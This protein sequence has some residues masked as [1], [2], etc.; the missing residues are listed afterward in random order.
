MIIIS[1]IVVHVQCPDISNANIMMSVWTLMR[2]L[3]HSTTWNFCT[4][5]YFQLNIHQ[6]MWF[7]TSVALRQSLH[8]RTVLLWLCAYDSGRAPSGHSIG[9]M[10]QP[11][12]ISWLRDCSQ[13]A[14][15]H[16]SGAIFTN[17]P[18]IVQ[19]V[20]EEDL[21]MNTESAVLDLKP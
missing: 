14:S 10:E 4:I 16:Q 11:T 2:L 5:Q 17:A 15:I 7:F 18:A 19:T 13:V 21:W 1:S 9:L 8:S 12:W 3:R 20:P 6:W